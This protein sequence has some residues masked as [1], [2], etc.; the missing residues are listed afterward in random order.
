MAERFEIV[1]KT[2]QLLLEDKKYKTLREILSTMNP[3]D[4]AAVFYGMDEERIRKIE[5]VQFPADGDDRQQIAGTAVAFQIGK[6]DPRIAFLR[7]GPIE[8]GRCFG[9]AVGSHKIGGDDALVGGPLK[10]GLIVMDACVQQQ[11]PHRR[12]GVHDGF[13]ISRRRGDKKRNGN[14]GVGKQRQKLR[15]IGV[16]HG[17]HGDRPS[18]F[19]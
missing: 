6:P 17:Q 10:L 8:G 5:H 19:R 1:E 18:L 16:G 14:A 13:F 4:I 12:G 15:K 3:G 11:F 7:H 2:L 9:A